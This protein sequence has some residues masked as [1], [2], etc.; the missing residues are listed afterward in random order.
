MWKAET[1]SVLYYKASTTRN[2]VYRPHPSLVYASYTKPRRSPPFPTNATQGYGLMLDVCAGSV[3]GGYQGGEKD[4]LIDFARD[5]SELDQFDLRR[6]KRPL[7][8]H[9]P[10]VF[11]GMLTRRV[12]Y[13]VSYCASSAV[14]RFVHSIPKLSLTLLAT[15]ASSAY[16]QYCS[17]VDAFVY[18]VEAPWLAPGDSSR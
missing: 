1:I 17:A 15:Q 16:D 6:Y 12:A 5:R 11:W 9:Q 13:L 14:C 7:A 2:L 10:S 18:T 8:Y 3:F 4:R